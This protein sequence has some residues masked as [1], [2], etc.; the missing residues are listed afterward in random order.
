MSFNRD[1]YRKWG[2]V[3]VCVMEYYSA[4]KNNEIM[5]FAATWM[6]LE[7]LVLS[8]VSE[9]EENYPMTSLICETKKETIQMSLLTKQK[10][11]QESLCL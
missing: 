2:G 10:Q 11:I 6:N 5:P 9:T 1:G 4:T 7:I 3:C 8:E